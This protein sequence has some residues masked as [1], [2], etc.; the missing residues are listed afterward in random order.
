MKRILSTLFLAFYL[1]N[2]FADTKMEYPALEP[3]SKLPLDA[4]IVPDKYS[5]F[6]LGSSVLL[7]QVG[8]GRRYRNVEN[9]KA[10]DISLNAYFSLPLIA[11]IHD[12]KLPV[13]P[14]IKYTYL[15]YKNSTPSSPYFGI[16]LEGGVAIDKPLYY[17]SFSQSVHFIPNFGLLWG[18]EREKMRFSQLQLNVIPAV[19]LIIGSGQLLF[20]SNRGTWDSLGA[21]ILALG[22]ASVLFSYS[23]GF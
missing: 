18:R 23:I 6:T 15:M 10:H 12:H 13:Y 11:G 7:Q 22:S 1:I 5:Y 17:H 2:V 21:T 3:I 19:G 14:F 4:P 9:F 8:I 20:G 16:T